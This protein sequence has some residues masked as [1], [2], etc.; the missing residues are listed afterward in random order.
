[1]KFKMPKLDTLVS[2]N[3]KNPSDHRNFIHVIAGKAVVSNGV[4]VVVDLREYVK[5]ECNIDNDE[6][7]KTLTSII[8]WMNGKSF[9]GTFW[10]DLTASNFV[11]LHK[12]GLQI[13]N[14]N[15]NKILVYE[16]ID[17][18]TMGM[19]ESLAPAFLNVPITVDRVGC[20]GEYINKITAAFKSELKIDNLLFDF[21]GKEKPLKFQLQRQNFIFGLIPLDY[22]STEDFT[23]FIDVADFGKALTNLVS[24]QG[25]ETI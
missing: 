14:P 24:S 11:T 22:K 21:C 23:A 5:K 1:M 15:Y 13:E 25:F 2:K 10:K 12:D 6:D 17:T 19:V 4:T 9:D 3:L 8:G 20:S 7:F 16:D 18:D